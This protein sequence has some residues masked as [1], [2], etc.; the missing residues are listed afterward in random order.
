[1][2][3]VERRFDAWV[4]V[5]DDVE[6]LKIRRCYQPMGQRRPVWAHIREGRRGRTGLISSY[7]MVALL[8][9]H[10]RRWQLGGICARVLNSRVKRF[11]RR[12]QHEKKDGVWG[13]VNDGWVGGWIF[14]ERGGLVQARLTLTAQ[15]LCRS[16]R[17]PSSQHLPLTGL[18]LLSGICETAHHCSWTDSFLGYLRVRSMELK[19]KLSLI[20]STPLWLPL[21]ISFIF[22]ARPLYPA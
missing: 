16:V 1:M 10:L 11:F 6:W 19:R 18:F 20:V 21:R 22:H 17:H 13:G 9:A 2:S 3:T 12:G 8:I 15:E 7:A 14:C 5:L 4:I